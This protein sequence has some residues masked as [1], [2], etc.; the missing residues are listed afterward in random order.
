MA[1][2]LIFYLLL[3]R[4]LHASSTLSISATGSVPSHAC[5]NPT[6][7]QPQQWRHPAWATLSGVV[8]QHLQRPAPLSSPFFLVVTAN[9][10]AARACHASI[11]SANASVARASCPSLASSSALAAARSQLTLLQLLQLCS[12]PWSPF[13]CAISH[14]GQR[15]HGPCRPTLASASAARAAPLWPAPLRPAP[16]PLSSHCRLALLA[17]R[18]TAKQGGSGGLAKPL[19]SLL[20][21]ATSLV[22]FPALSRPCELGCGSQ[23]VILFAPLLALCSHS[24]SPSYVPTLIWLCAS[25]FALRVVLRPR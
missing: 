5:C 21:Y 12:S 20:I 14:F 15:L 3:F 16:P 23:V 1:G 2:A 24:L 22:L 18:P 6:P 10:R 19:A 25:R 11:I 7:R 13:H 4:Y 17:Q 9:A 8:W